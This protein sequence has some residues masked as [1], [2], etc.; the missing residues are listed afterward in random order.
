MER[1]TDG[2][3]QDLAI[4]HRGACHD[5]KG[6]CENCNLHFEVVC[7]LFQ[8]HCLQYTQSCPYEVQQ[9]FRIDNK[10]LKKKFR[11]RQTEMRK[12]ATVLTI[13]NCGVNQVNGEYR[14]DDTRPEL[15]TKLAHT[16]WGQDQNGNNI[17]MEDWIVVYRDPK[18]S[19]NDKELW[20]IKAVQLKFSVNS[21]L[22]LPQ[23][24]QTKLLY[25]AH[26]NSEEVPPLQGWRTDSGVKGPVPS[27]RI[28]SKKVVVHNNR[29]LE[30]AMRNYFRE[31]FFRHSLDGRNI[32]NL[33]IMDHISKTMTGKPA[34][35]KPGLQE[36]KVSW[37][38]L[39]T[40]L[41]VDMKKN[42]TPLKNFMQKQSDAAS[43]RWA[44]HGTKAENIKSIASKNF[45]SSFCK[46]QVHGKGHYFSPDPLLA[47]RYA[48]DT[49]GQ[50]GNAYKCL[51]LCQ[52]LLGNTAASKS[53]NGDS[54]T[55]KDFCYVIPDERQI[56]PV[57][58]V[59][60]RV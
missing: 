25:H 30:S 11:D 28:H 26:S 57:Y 13:T 55:H 3:I 22:T 24:E 45:K 54:N 6:E 39:M 9:V 60:V 23:T 21:I 40:E 31:Y 48:P 34:P 2:E 59:V 33:E 52:T 10:K 50:D 18:K 46:R 27:I 37:D 17:K 32:S 56:W 29:D 14:R 8:R 19:R 20:R 58:V 1:Y 7:D 42:A 38:A 51:V 47:F 5:H 12:K 36:R 4:C 49:Y 44:W 53:P 43:I 35:R 16:Q 15:F 41:K